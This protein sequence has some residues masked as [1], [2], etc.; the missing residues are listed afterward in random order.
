MLRLPVLTSAVNVSEGRDLAVIDRIAGSAGP[1]CLDVHRDPHHHRSV[2]TVAGEDAARAVAT[3]AIRRLDLRGHDGVHPRIG[4]VD[5]VPFV[6]LPGDPDLSAALR[7]RDAFCAWAADVHDL[8]CFVY[9]P[10]RSLPDVRRHAF[11]ALRPDTGPDRPHPSAGAAAVGAR[12]PLVAYNVWLARPDI[13]LARE[14][15]RA[16]RSPAVRALGLRVGDRVQ[17]SMNLVEPLEVGP[18]EAYDAVADL[19]A[20]AGAELVGLLPAAVL[21]A[22]PA[23]R[24]VQLDLAEDRTLEARLADAGVTVA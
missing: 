1:M 17:V 18:A 12:R 13:V 2:V 11:G 21:R 7:A 15:A 24:W 9:G 16:V 10:E 8:P 20:V 22:V 14:I 5:V 4:V 6:P 19:A 3:E 23:H